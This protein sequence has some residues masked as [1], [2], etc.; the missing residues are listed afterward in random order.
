MAIAQSQII[1]AVESAAAAVDHVAYHV[2]NVDVDVLKDHSEG[3]V[4]RLTA[5][6]TT[7]RDE[8][9]NSCSQSAHEM[10][11][12]RAGSEARSKLQL[13]ALQSALIGTQLNNMIEALP[14]DA[15]DANG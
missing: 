3:L 2:G 7:L 12:N 8:V 15:C 4:H 14:E 1:D 9:C 11:A 6:H 13:L 5:A 10:R